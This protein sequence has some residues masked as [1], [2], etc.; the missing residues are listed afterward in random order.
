MVHLA[1]NTLGLFVVVSRELVRKSMR[2][3]T[4][5]R[6]RTYIGVIKTA[7]VTQT[8][9]FE[10]NWVVSINDSF[11]VGGLFRHFDPQCL[12]S[13]NASVEQGMCPEGGNPAV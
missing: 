9:L 2:R 4:S 13:L 11:L 8:R 6:L 12:D 1:K 7:M 3:W 10:V 5:L